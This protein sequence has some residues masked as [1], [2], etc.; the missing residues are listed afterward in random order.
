[1]YEQIIITSRDT[2]DDLSGLPE[3]YREVHEY[4]E[5]VDGED[6]CV[7]VCFNV[8]FHADAGDTISVEI[9]SK[10]GEEGEG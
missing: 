8:D 7:D 5:P 10:D 3:P 2:S 9:S 1:M 4:G 6:P